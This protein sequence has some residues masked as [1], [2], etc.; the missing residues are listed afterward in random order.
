MA[1][2]KKIRQRSE[3]P[4][5]DRWATEDLYASDEAWE[6]DLN[7]L[8]ELAKELASFAGKIS[9]DP[10][11]LL[12]YMTLSEQVHVLASS[13]ANYASRKGDE[14]TR[15]AAYQAMNGKF[16]SAYVALSSATSFETPEI[17]SIS[18][19]EL[20]KFY[21]AEPGWSATAAT[22]PTSAV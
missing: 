3:I 10:K 4:E 16:R 11:A 12:D 13:I 7:K 14:D 15:V 1:E 19:E 2:M 21:A 5:K 17:M 9:T 20:E 18:D 8:N 6:A 22:S